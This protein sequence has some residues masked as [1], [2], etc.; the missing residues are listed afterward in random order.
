MSI[1]RRRDP[2]HAAALS[3]AQLLLF[4]FGIFD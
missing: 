3:A 4:V 2:P 1:E